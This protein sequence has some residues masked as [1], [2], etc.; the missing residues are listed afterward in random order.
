MGCGARARK[1]AEAFSFKGPFSRCREST[2]V[3]LALTTYRA[4]SLPPPNKR[5]P[6]DTPPRAHT[7]IRIPPSAPSRP[8]KCEVK[9]HL[10]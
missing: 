8:T 4:I 6:D 10:M 5:P 2:G 9:L 1:Q 7:Y 3:A